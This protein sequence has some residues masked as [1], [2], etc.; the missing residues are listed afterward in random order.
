MLW[1]RLRRAVISAFLS[2][3]IIFGSAQAY[4]IPNGVDPATV[5]VGRLVR[6]NYRT[7]TGFAD[8]DEE[9]VYASQLDQDGLFTIPDGYVFVDSSAVL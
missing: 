2:T 1:S 5:L 4:E 6:D 9:D 7:A 8:V 3:L